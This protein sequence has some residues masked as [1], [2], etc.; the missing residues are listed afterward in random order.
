MT[1]WFSTAGN[2]SA[3][4]VASRSWMTSITD[5]DA[6]F[7][8]KRRQASLFSRYPRQQAIANS[9]LHEHEAGAAVRDYERD[10]NRR[11]A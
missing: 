7:P 8:R 6:G 11:L 4:T 1:T 3:T 2:A 9:C 10:G 5:A